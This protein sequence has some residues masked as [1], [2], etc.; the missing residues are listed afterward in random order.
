[1]P[2]MKPLLLAV[3]FTPT[4]IAR[5]SPLSTV[6]GMT[7]VLHR[8]LVVVVTGAAAVVNELAAVLGKALPLVSL[9]PLAPPTTTIV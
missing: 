6:E 1:M 9:T 4:S 7:L 8:L 3:N 5:L 2:V